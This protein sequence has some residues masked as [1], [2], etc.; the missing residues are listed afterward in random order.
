MTEADW[1]TCDDARL[2]VEFIRDRLND[3]K[4]R[5]FACVAAGMV[6]PRRSSNRRKPRSAI[7][8][9]EA[10]ADGADVRREM[11]RLR[12]LWAVTLSD[13]RQSAVETSRE[14]TLRHRQT[15]MA[16]ALR[17]IIG[18]PFRPITINPAWQT[19]TVVSLA[20]AAHDNRTL[21]AGTLE[22]ERIA[23]L[24]DALEEAGCDSADILK[25]L[26][27]PG[28]HVRGCFTLDAILGK[29]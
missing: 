8:T 17:C 28:P 11:E 20:Q 1:L 4:A 22:N 10:F 23:V 12:G 18:N 26:R 29:Q 25:H 2:M 14:S 27:S 13:A 15:E 6:S 5:L 9:A 24:A 16:N 21:P 7:A 19:L 3:R